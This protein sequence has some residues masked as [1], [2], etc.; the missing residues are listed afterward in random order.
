MVPGTRIELASREAL[1]P[2]ASVSTNSTTRAHSI[3]YVF[4]LFLPSHFEIDETAEGDK[5]VVS[6]EAPGEHS[7]EGVA[8]A[9][10]GKDEVKRAFGGAGVTWGGNEGD[11]GL[12]RDGSHGSRKIIDVATECADNKERNSVEEDLIREREGESFYKKLSIFHETTD[13]CSVALDL[14]KSFFF[15]FFII[16]ND[17]D[18]MKKF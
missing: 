15:G 1:A 11:G 2:K 5:G 8:R 10:R 9:E 17:M 16:A 12:N 6:E 3:L 4:F 7:P 14:T 13:N 18:F